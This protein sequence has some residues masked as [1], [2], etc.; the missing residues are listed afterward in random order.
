MRV[1]LHD[2]STTSLSTA[3]LA[4]VEA[5]LEFFHY[6]RNTPDAFPPSVLKALLELSAFFRP[7]VADAQELAEELLAFARRYNIPALTGGLEL[8]QAA[9]RGDRTAVR[10]RKAWLAG[11]WL[12]ATRDLGAAALE[13]G[14]ERIAELCDDA[15]WASAQSRALLTK[16]ELREVHRAERRLVR[17]MEKWRALQVVAVRC[18]PR[19]REHVARRHRRTRSASRRAPPG[20]DRPRPA[21]SDA[22]DWAESARPRLPLSGSSGR[23]LP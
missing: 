13:G 6:A 21:G 15:A 3:E 12:K 16:P 14:S 19:A 1:D 22:G 9:A 23:C 17:K 10:A 2:P 4:D 5:A 18:R 7:G 20:D 8:Y 11:V